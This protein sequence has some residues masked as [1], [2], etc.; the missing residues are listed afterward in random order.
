MPKNAPLKVVD[1]NSLYDPIDRTMTGLFQVYLR[2]GWA[3][4]FGAKVFMLKEVFEQ[5]DVISINRF[6]KENDY[7]TSPFELL[8][9]KELDDGLL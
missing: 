5:T 6:L 2:Q 9:R 3:V 8:D 7:Y 4:K 1:G